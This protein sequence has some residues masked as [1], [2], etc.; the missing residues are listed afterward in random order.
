MHD[1]ITG[2]SFSYLIITIIAE[3]VAASKSTKRWVVVRPTSSSLLRC[4]HL[5]RSITLQIRLFLGVLGRRT[6]EISGD[7]RECSFSFQWLSVLLRRLLHNSFVE[8]EAGTGI[9]A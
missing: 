4:N 1:V 2:C 8:E 6:A 5:V 9:P 3:I 7:C